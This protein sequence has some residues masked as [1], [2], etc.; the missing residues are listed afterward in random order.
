MEEASLPSCSGGCIFFKAQNWN[1]WLFVLKLWY[2]EQRWTCSDFPAKHK[3]QR[4]KASPRQGLTRSNSS[5]WAWAMSAF[6][7]KQVPGWFTIC[8]NCARGV[9]C[10]FSSR[11]YCILGYFSS[12]ISWIACYQVLL[13]TSKTSLDHV[14]Q[15][16]CLSL[17]HGKI[18]WCR[19][20]SYKCVSLAD[21]ETNT[22]TEDTSG[23]SLAETCMSQTEPFVYSS[24]ENADT[25]LY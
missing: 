16:T 6:A 17:L 7:Y 11:R 3:I 5:I 2:F 20:N 4:Q 10:L 23:Q 22:T 24:Y 9:S 19:L 18:G 8:N 12:N 15:K 25:K 21:T 1:I 14:K 13:N